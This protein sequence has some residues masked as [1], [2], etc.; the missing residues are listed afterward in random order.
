MKKFSKG[1]PVKDEHFAEARQLWKA[2]NAY[3]H[4][5]GALEACLSE[6]SWIV[7]VEEIKKRE[8]DLT[9]RNPNRTDSETLPPP[10]EIVAELME[11]EREIMSILEELDELLGNNGQGETESCATIL[12]NIADDPSA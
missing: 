6:R 1:S 9:A 11:R 2:W 12:K 4:G 5:K 8:Y 10:I 3:R 7:P